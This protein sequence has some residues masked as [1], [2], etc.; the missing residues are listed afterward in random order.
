MPLTHLINFS[1]KQGD[2]HHLTRPEDSGEGALRAMRLALQSA[3][4]EPSE[5]SSINCHA[6]STPA[7]DICEAKALRSLLNEDQDLIDKVT[8]TANKGAIGHCFGAAGAIESIF[9]I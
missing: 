9:A 6:T 2:A 5:V 8:V 7:G 1:Y 3:G 4:M